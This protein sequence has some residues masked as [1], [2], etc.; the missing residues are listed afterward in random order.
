MMHVGEKSGGVSLSVSKI[1]KFV[2]VVDICNLMDLGFQGPA[3]TWSNLRK[4]FA[5]IKERI[6]RGF[7]SPS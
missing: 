4:G 2:K 3:F 5:N 1:N 6:D 7:A